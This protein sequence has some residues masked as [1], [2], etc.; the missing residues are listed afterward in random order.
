MQYQEFLSLSGATRKECPFQFYQ[1]YIEPA[2]MENDLL[3]PTKESVV[4]HWHRFGPLGFSKDSIASLTNA[5]KAI[6]QVCRFA[7]RPNDGMIEFA[8]F[9]ATAAYNN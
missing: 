2:Y 1:W 4:E 8:K 7:R 9:I 6:Q 5:V 3:F